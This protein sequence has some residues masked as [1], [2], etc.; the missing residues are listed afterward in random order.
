MLLRPVVA[1]LTTAVRCKAPQTVA[2]GSGGEILASLS[3][4]GGELLVPAW[5]RSISANGPSANSAATTI[6]G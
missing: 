3:Q 5:P 4:R 6:T 1:A 2:I